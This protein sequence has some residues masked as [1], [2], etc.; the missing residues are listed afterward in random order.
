MR[1]TTEYARSG[2]LH[3]AYQVIGAGPDL[4]WIPGWLSNVEHWWEHP[5]PASFIRRL[6]SFARVILFDK[7]GTG[8]SDRHGEIPGIDER[9]DD[10]LAVLDAVGVERGH[11][12]GITFEGGALAS[13]F[14]AMHPDRVRSLILY[15][16]T[17]RFVAADD[18]AWGVPPDRFEDVL[19]ALGDSW[20]SGTFALEHLAP[21]HTDDDA[22][23]EWFGRWARVSASPGAAVEMFRR[24]GRIDVRSVLSSIRVPALVLHR[25]DDPVVAID[26]GRAMASAIDGA[27]F[28]E[29]EGR[30]TAIFCGDVDPIL[31]AIRGFVAGVHEA[32][33]PARVVSTLYFNDIVGS[34]EQA[35][36]MGD[37]AWREYLDRFNAIVRRHLAAVGGREVTTTGDGFLASFDAPVRGVRC[38]LDIG[39]ALRQAGI[40]ARAGMHIGECEVVGDDLI[41][42]AVHVAS[43]V[44]AAAEAG[45]VLVSEPLR[46]LVVGSDIAC[47]SRGTQTLKGVP[48]SWSLF[49]AH[50]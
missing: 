1:P 2:D 9:L 30:D 17:P 7:R 45:E 25:R 3:V 49:A 26:A 38:A 31:A 24:V 46:D 40:A 16:A 42:L 44:T 4:V 10:L 41:G 18:W 33:A 6:S 11:I 5:L 34:T 21:S 14:A 8:L 35:A 20:S 23:R 32:P 36:E 15:G 47:E 22:L 12:L 39:Q 28:V 50:V 13:L 19:R 29:L 48:G 27:R 43:R 37:A